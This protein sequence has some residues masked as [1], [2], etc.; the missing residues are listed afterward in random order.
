MTL[1][2]EEVQ[3]QDAWSFELDVQLVAY[4]TWFFF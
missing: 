3:Q 4:M 2:V 1:I